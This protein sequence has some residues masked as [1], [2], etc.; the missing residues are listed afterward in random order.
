MDTRVRLNVGDL[1]QQ[2]AVY[3]VEGWLESRSQGN[4]MREWLESSRISHRKQVNGW[5][6]SG[7]EAL[8]LIFE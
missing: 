8:C 4:Q 1:G 5:L 7:Q 3:V 6:E 2:Y